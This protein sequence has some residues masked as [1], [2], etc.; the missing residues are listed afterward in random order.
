MGAAGI[1]GTFAPDEIATRLGVGTPLVIQLLGALLFAFAMVNWMA[2]GSLIGGIYNRPI[3]VGNLT[4]F[5]IGALALAKAVMAG[6]RR[7]AF[8][9]AAGIYIVFAVGFGAVLF[10]SPVPPGKGTRV[11][12]EREH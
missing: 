11:A 4:H 1:A 12:P 6:E 9:V 3:A 8:V 10:R 7:I 2:R 5:L